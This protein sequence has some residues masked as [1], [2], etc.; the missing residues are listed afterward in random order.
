MKEYIEERAVDI[1]N[2][3][4]DCNATVRQTAKKFGVSKSTVHKDVTERLLQINPTLARKARKVLD[5]NKQERH[6]RGG[7]ATREKYLHKAP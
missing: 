7:M 3:I 6:I 5:V 2:Y 4:I 1:A